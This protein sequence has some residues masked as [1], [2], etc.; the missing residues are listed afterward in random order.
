MKNI[1]VIGAGG[2]AAVIID[3]IEAMIQQGDNI[4][5]V[6]IL[7]DRND[8]TKFIGYEI[9]NKISYAESYNYDNTEFVIA[10]GDNKI[11]KNIAN[12]FNKLKYFTPIHP[13]AIIGNNVN[14]KSG[15][16][17][18]PRVV[19]NSN[20]YI[21]NH[22]IINSGAIIEHDNVISSFVHI[23][24]GATLCGGISV[25]EGT[26]IGANTTIIQTRKVGSNTIVGAGSTVIN[27]IESNVVVVG[28]PAKKIR[29]CRG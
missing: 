7:D 3:I 29:E 17:V 18:M 21:G 19:I 6:G 4:R 5:I 27:D 1:I 11:R 12:K 16:V 9:L 8:I 13:T 20:T 10:I 26:H 28:S 23:S 15:T 2:H 22:S 14:I 24:P 25:G